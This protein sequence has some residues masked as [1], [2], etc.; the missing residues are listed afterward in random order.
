VLARKLGID[1]SGF[2]DVLKEPTSG[3]RAMTGLAA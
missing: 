3:E 2:G 1:I